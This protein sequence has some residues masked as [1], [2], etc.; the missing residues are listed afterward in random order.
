MKH[1]NIM[2]Y[3]FKIPDNDTNKSNL[4]KLGSKAPN[5]S[6]HEHISHPRP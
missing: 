3:T 6:L 1:A 5:G 4:T 2:K